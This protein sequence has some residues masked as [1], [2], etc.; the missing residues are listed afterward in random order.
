[1]ANV[2][3]F[4][5]VHANGAGIDIG[6]REIYVSIDGKQVVR[7]K[8]FTA[9]YHDCCRYLQENG[10]SS[11]AMEATGVYWMSL[12]SI[13][14]DYGIEVC[15]VHPR[16][17]QQVKGR[18]SDVTDSQWIQK[19]YSA[20]ILRESIVAKGLLKDLRSLVRDRNDIVT[21]GSSYVNKMQKYLEMMNIKLRNVISQIHGSSGLKIIT[22]IVAGERDPRKLAALCHK[23]ILDKKYEDVVKSLEG[24]YNPTYVALLKENFRLWEEHQ[25]SAKNIEKEI[26]VL[27]DRLNQ[28]KDI[29]VVSKS[30]PSRNHQPD[31]PNLHETIIQINGG[32]DLTVIS[33]INDYSS[34]RLLAEIGT[35]LSRFPTVNHFVSW[36]GLSPKNKQSGRMKRRVKVKTGNAGLIFRQSAQSLLISKHNAIGAFIRRLAARKGSRIAIKAGARKLAINFYNALTKGVEYVETGAVQYLEHL[37]QKEIRLLGKL[38]VKHGFTVY[39]EIDN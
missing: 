29:P 1:M 8:T 34:L 15:L 32:V 14:E 2:V 19:L 25:L 3:I 13:L 39:N 36:L 27:L 6:S 38:A 24:N 28:N 37:R 35:D 20:G 10:I 22:S 16:E 4:D 18:K 17:V 33:G 26:E 5:E 12:Y 23:S 21:M 30:K 9:D 7:F 31:I 11:V